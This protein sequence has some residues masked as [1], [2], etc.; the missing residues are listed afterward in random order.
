MPKTINGDA[1]EISQPY[2]EG[3]TITAAEAKALNQTRSENIGNNLRKKLA[4]L[5]ENG[6]SHEDLAAVVAE[7]DANYIFTLASVSASKKLDPYE[8]EALKIAKELVKAKLAA[9]GR[10][11]TDVPKGMTK[12]DW[13]EKLEA[14]Y[15]DVAS[16]E[17]VVATAKKTVDA[18][19]KNADS[20]L[21]ALGDSDI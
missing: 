18:R 3:H 7:A 17:R 16:N 11:T 12:E 21:E 8:R 9:Q 5:K 20:L 19:K 1:F 13:E 2:A 14:T 15:E 10:K 4:E 6:A